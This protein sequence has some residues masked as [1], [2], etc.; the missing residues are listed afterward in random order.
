MI[1]VVIKST[2]SWY[3]V[4][5]P[6]HSEWK[7][8]ITGKHR[9]F[10]FQLTN[11]VAVGD[12]VEVVP[13][14]ETN[15]GL[16]KEILPRKNYVVRQSPR[17]K[18]QLHFL[19][20]NIDQAIVLTTIIEPNLKQGFIDRFLLMT[21]PYD[22]PTI[23]IFNKSDLYGEEE[24]RLYNECENLYTPLGYKVLLVSAANNHNI[25]LLKDLLKDKVSL[26]AGQS[27]VGKS[28]L[29]NKLDKNLE[30]TTDFISDYS[31]KGQHTTTFAEMHSLSFGGYIIDTPG[32]KTLSFNHLEP[33][34]IMHNFREIFSIGQNCKYA[35]CTHRNE[36]GCSVKLAVST[37]QIH[38]WR[39]YNY[40]QLMEEIED[41]NYWERHK[42]Y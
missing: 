30:L 22:I 36:P 32:I 15:T 26:I 19:A 31:G 6:D 2:G 13:E 1:G 3:K 8:R 27:G 11:P 42:D 24:M 35:N 18:H 10:G 37:G 39:Y 5:F 23:I 40:L 21:E 41:Q 28:S 33:Q 29:I 34:D 4:R 25:D 20:S 7:C 16:I 38:E 14:S 9:L 17:Q 12:W